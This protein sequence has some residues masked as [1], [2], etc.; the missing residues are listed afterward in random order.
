MA[1]KQVKLVLNFKNDKILKKKLCNEIFFV[2]ILKTAGK[3]VKIVLNF[4]N[5]KNRFAKFEKGFF[6]GVSEFFENFFF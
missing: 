5:E 6:L 4:E 3:R 2:F 1:G